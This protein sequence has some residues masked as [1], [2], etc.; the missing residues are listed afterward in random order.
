[1]TTTTNKM[2]SRTRRIDRIVA[3]FL[4]AG[5]LLWLL[6]CAGLAFP[7]QAVFYLIAGWIPF[8]RRVAPQLNVNWSN[9]AT[10]VLCLFT[11]GLGAHWFLSWIDASR[12]RDS[13]E[14]LRRWRFA[15][16]ASITAAILLLLIAGICILGVAHQTVWMATSEQPII[17]ST[18]ETFY[19][20]ESQKNLKQIGAAASDYAKANSAL[21][22][23]AT[24]D[25]HGRPLRSWQTRL[26]P[27]IGY[28]PLYDEIDHTLPWDARENRAAFSRQVMPFVHLKDWSR[29]GFEY[30]ITSYAGNAWLLGGSQRWKADEITDGTSNTILCGEAATEP[31]AWGDPVNWRDPGEGLAHR[32]TSF[33]GAFHGF[34]LFN[35]ADGHV[36]SVSNRI[37]PAVFRALCTPAA[38]DEIRQTE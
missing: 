38:G 20:E 4:G 29:G 13:A 15:W 1:M 31:R 16:T 12:T 21:S 36:T 33:G 11:V 25:E 5:A 18:F 24:F 8:I 19:R 14:P 27:F 28:Q 34:T 23:A 2:A 9:V 22:A 7:F 10:A 35:F 26:L 32:P 3:V 6:S 17:E 37:D 30:A